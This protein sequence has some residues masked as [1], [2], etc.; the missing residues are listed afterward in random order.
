M[1]YE[2][3]NGKILG[4]YDQTVQLVVGDTKRKVRLT[5]KD[6]MSRVM[7]RQRSILA[8]SNMYATL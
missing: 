5:W 4:R 1:C 3:S 8:P 7:R 2:Q 6:I